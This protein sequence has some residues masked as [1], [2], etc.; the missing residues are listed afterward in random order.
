MD[1]ITRESSPVIY[2]ESGHS[3]SVSW[4]CTRFECARPGP[5]P[6]R[7]LSA[8][9]VAPLLG[10]PS[11]WVR[12]GSPS[13]FRCPVCQGLPSGSPLA[14]PLGVRLAVV[15]GQGSHGRGHLGLSGP[16]GGEA[17]L[18]GGEAGGDWWVRWAIGV[19]PALFVRV[20][21]SDPQ[22]SLHSRD[23]DTDDRV[24]SP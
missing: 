23:T 5:W 21:V 14:G 3:S 19:I 4:A 11:W 18:M 6:F 22:P 24:V 17:G 15:L 8:L 2:S 7:R 13:F 10:L 16:A 20:A 9:P 12:P 1:S